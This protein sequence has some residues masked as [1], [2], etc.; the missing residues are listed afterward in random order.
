M[1]KLSVE[2]CS[3]LGTKNSSVRMILFRYLFSLAMSAFCFSSMICSMVRVAVVVV[4]VV[5]V[6]LDA[7]VLLLLGEEGLDENVDVLALLA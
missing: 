7:F 1:I 6:V 2:F 4:V 3:S 5:V